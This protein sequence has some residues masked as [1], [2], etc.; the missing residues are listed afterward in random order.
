MRP[1]PLAVPHGRADRATA[2]VCPFDLALTRA[3][4][5]YATRP[6]GFVQP[7][8]PGRQG[9]SKYG[10]PNGAWENST[11][12]KPQDGL[13]GGTRPQWPSKH[14]RVGPGAGPRTAKTAPG[15]RSG[16]G[17]PYSGGV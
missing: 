12:T 10:H 3:H 7:L 8:R 15:A 4:Q 5:V 1:A 13:A 2:L 16:P 11:S 9:P 17:G 14:G 6:P